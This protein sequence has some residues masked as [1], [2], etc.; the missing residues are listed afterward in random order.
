VT[1]DPGVKPTDLP[2]VHWKRDM[3]IGA[4]KEVPSVAAS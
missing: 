3:R 4:A 2:P 1:A